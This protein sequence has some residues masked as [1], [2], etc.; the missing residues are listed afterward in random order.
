MRGSAYIGASEAVTLIEK[1][2]NA[3]S[4]VR[5]ATTNDVESTVSKMNELFDKLVADGEAIRRML[6]R[7]PE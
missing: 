5:D 6:A 3:I 1:K 7:I 2:C 4:A